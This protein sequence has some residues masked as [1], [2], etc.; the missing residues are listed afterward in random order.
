M[1][2]NFPSPIQTL[3]HPKFSYHNVNVV[4]KRDDLIHPVISGN[5]YRKLKY[6]LAQ[7]K[8]D[9]RQGIISFGGAYS[10]HIHA[11]AFA[12][13][14]HNIP[15]VGVIR[16]YEQYATNATLSQAQRWGM[17]LHFVDKNTYRHR[18]SVEYQQTL[19]QHF[20]NYVLVPEG[21]SNSQALIGVADVINE[22]NQQLSFQ[23][24]I[25]AVGSGGTLA[26]LISASHNEQKIWG[27][28]VLK[29][30]EYLE[31]K[32]N[33]LLGNKAPKM[34]NWQLI[35]H[36]HQGGYA[37]IPPDYLQW[38]WSISQQLAIPFEP[39]YTG[40]MLAGF[41]D[42]L[43]KGYFNAGETVVLLHTGGLQG[44]N[45]LIEQ[46][47]LPNHWQTMLPSD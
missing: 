14:Q 19:L 32:I 13:M 2:V 30:A 1:I 42:L 47:Q 15:C 5:K 9:N 33:Q 17:Q 25:T 6:N 27:I 34:T 41:F 31:Q 18:D 11:L 35:H 46:N 16:G 3:R 26:G 45:G 29:Q 44:I 24:L 38:L 23:H 12:C 39:I 28:A 40:K 43:D 10:N 37:K 7:I 36:Y 20:P 4:I 22:L 21:G 8:Q